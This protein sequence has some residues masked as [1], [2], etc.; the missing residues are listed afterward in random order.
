MVPTG[1]KVIVNMETKRK[2]GRSPIC[3]SKLR[4]QLAV[5]LTDSQYSEIVQ[6]AKAEGRT[7]SNYIHWVLF[8]SKKKGK[9]S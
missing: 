8:G 1:V 2:T 5:R 9:A 6:R 3:D 7:A 4:K